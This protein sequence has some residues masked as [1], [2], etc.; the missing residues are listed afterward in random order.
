MQ[1]TTY[2][3]LIDTTGVDLRVHFRVRS[4][5][6][7]RSTPVGSITV[8]HGMI[9]LCAFSRVAMC[10]RLWSSDDVYGRYV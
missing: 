2:Y 8:G 4:H 9:H 3:D 6:L 7:I 10:I 5:L 1:T